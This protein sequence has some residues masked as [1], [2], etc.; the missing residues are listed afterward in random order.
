MPEVEPT[1][2]ILRRAELDAYGDVRRVRVPV[3]GTADVNEVPV[4]G[5]AVPVVASLLE[6]TNA[7]HPAVWAGYRNRKT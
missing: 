5:H 1:T 3:F 6:N 2:V 7:G 4:L